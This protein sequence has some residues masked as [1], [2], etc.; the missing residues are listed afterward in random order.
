MKPSSNKKLIKGIGIFFRIGYYFFWGFLG[1]S[2]LLVIFGDLSSITDIDRF[3]IKLPGSEPVTINKPPTQLLYFAILNILLI[4]LSTIYVF[5]QIIELT[6]SVARNEF[7][8]RKNAIRIRKIAL[9]FIGLFV[10]YLVIDIA[11]VEYVSA[12]SASDKITFPGL[13]GYFVD[14]DKLILPLLLLVLAEV[15]RV[16]LEMKEEQDLTI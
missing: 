13:F 11:T 8:I 3:T 9:I 12:H 2:V 16:G 5:K 15:F 7:F 6:S 14:L 10:V 1:L 4:S